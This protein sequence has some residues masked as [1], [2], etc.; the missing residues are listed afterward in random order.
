MPK[1]RRNGKPYTRGAK[2][3]D[4]EREEIKEEVAKWDRFGFTQRRI[5]E[6]LKEVLNVTVGQVQVGNY[7]ASIR[8]EYRDSKLM[9]R[10]EV[11]VQELKVLMDVRAESIA[12][13]DRSKRNAKKIVTKRVPPRKCLKCKG[14][15]NAGV[16]GKCPVCLGKKKIQFPPETTK[17]VEG[18]TPASEYMALILQTNRAIR[19]LLGLDE[20]IKLD[21]TTATLDLNALIREQYSLVGG[22][23]VIVHD[24]D[25]RI[26]EGIPVLT[27]GRP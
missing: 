12:A 3:T 13:W 16:K 11:V 2:F 25:S 5:A 22:H 17:T 10:N 7:I 20:A 23:E 27:E 21:V 19:E 15:G 26:V 1:A 9:N 4:L 6:K 8:Q 14:T 24:V 18:R